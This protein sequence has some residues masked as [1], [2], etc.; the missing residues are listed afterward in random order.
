MAEI[1][2]TICDGVSH[3]SG[4]SVFPPSAVKYQTKKAKAEMKHGG[5]FN[6]LS[7]PCDSLAALF[8]DGRRRDDERRER[9]RY[10]P[11]NPAN[12]IE[13]LSIVLHTLVDFSSTV[14]GDSADN[15]ASSSVGSSDCR[16][17]SGYVAR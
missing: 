9:E 4:R 5:R 12:P 8:P 14:D 13:Y 17:R 7:F 15:N 6:Q 2:P 1:H 16:N 11:V 10:S 3:T